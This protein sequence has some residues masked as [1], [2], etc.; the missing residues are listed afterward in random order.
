[1]VLNSRV[2][3]LKTLRLPLIAAVF[4]VAACAVF[5][6]SQNTRALS[7]WSNST[8]PAVLSDGDT[9]SVELGM[10]FR[11]SKAT[12]VTGVKF[13][14]G[15]QNTGTHTGSLW[16]KSGQKL[17]SV[18][19]TGE[20]A[21]G[22]QTATFASPVNI[23]ANTTYV[24]SYFAPKGHYSVD[25]NYFATKSV[26]SGS[27]T[28]LKGGT[29]G[30]NGVYRYSSSSRFPNASYKSSNYWVDVLTED[31]DTTAPTVSLTAPATGS[32]VSGS[33][34]LTATATDNLAVA[35]V[36][37]QLNGAPL[38]SADTTSPYATSWDTTTVANGNYS[39]SAI[40]TDTYGNAT[41]SSTVTVTVN[42]QVVIPPV[43]TSASLWNDTATPTVLAATEDSAAVELG[44]K[45]RASAAA[46]VTGAKFFKGTGNT[47]THTASLWSSDGT[48]LATATF[49]GETATGW[50]TVA[51]SQ[52]VNI[53]A[54]TTYVVSYY[55]P[56]GHYAYD[57]GYFAA[58]HTNA[59]N[60]LTALA[61]GTDGGNGVYSYGTSSFPTS[62]WQSSN[63]WVDVIA[64]VGDVTPPTPTAPQVTSTVP[65]SGATGV[66]T[67][68][69]IS[70]KF[71]KA[72]D[73]ATVNST[74]VKLTQGGTAVAASVAYVSATNTITL[75]PTASLAENTSYTVSVSTGVKSGEVVSLATTYT[76]G[77]TTVGIPPTNTQTCDSTERVMVTVLNQSNYPAYPVGT[78][79]YVP[80]GADPWGGCFP[81][82]NNTGVP[83]GTQLTP[84]TGPC[85][86]T[87]PNT[88]IDSK[89]VNCD[90]LDIRALGVSI[91]KSH[92]EGRVYVDSDRC[93]TASFTI[94]DSS[95]H[96]PDK[97]NRALRTC[98]YTAQRVDLSGGGS[99]AECVNCTIKDSYLHG[100]L[101]DLAGKAHNSTVRAG[102][103]SVIE[104]NTLH[105]AVKSY[106]ATDGS[107]ESS[108]CSGN[109][110]GYSHDAT[111]MF[112]ST[113]RRNFYAGTTGG[114]CAW[115]GST[116][117]AGASQVRDIKFIE[118][119]FQRGTM[120]AWGWNPAAYLCGGY[121]SVANLEL[122]LP[123]NEFTGN[124]WDNGK[125]L[126]PAQWGSIEQ[127]NA[128][129][130]QP[131]CTW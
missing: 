31:L 107:G 106:D 96:T 43:T 102:G 84:Y 25:E 113:L 10:K 26:T 79:V 119:V 24:V 32:T 47:G 87:T 110:T 72:L 92:V 3:T 62:S 118:N 20:S 95:V 89:T 128:C 101:E 76:G 6:M 88:V 48:R 40:A 64:T 23:A 104:H 15:A 90:V 14:K 65:A 99:M 112:N 109:Q 82:P 105:C 12:T 45:F 58:A 127:G 85:I 61:D 80:G 4:L 28:A 74:N 18:T 8:T 73:P 17:A 78:M 5:F 120:A 7:V 70:L 52:P 16:T 21:S 56:N 129:G 9:A 36:Q 86:V 41:T 59:D 50:Q 93:D 57:S 115:G 71:D 68:T 130:S 38:G 98:S 116:G 75:T 30:P 103:N 69:G 60:N 13:F 66:S 22:W 29:D 94:T 126:T 39:L 19:F 2:L 34:N 97:L 108:G 117:G 27:L 125:P 46:T 33:V 11:S 55:A 35:K 83:A 81:G 100:P 121:G 49:T 123:G 111:V 54:G 131:Q 114:Y 77:F 91:T 122:D 44:V 37:F 42:N 1:M 53:T 63:Y 124:T 67:S 51:F